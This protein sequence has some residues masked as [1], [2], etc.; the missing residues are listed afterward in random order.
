MPRLYQDCVYS[1]E[2]KKSKFITY[3]HRTDNEEDAKAFLMM[4]K[5]K[6]W[7]ATHHCTALIIGTT[8]RSNDDGEPAQTAGHPMLAVLQHEQMDHILAVV[9]RYFGGTKLGT[10]GLVRA[11]SSGV[12]NALKEAI[13]CKVQKVNEYE[14]CYPYDQT[15]KIESFLRR[16]HL[17]AGEQ[18]YGEQVTLHFFS[19]NDETEALSAATNGRIVPK[20]LRTIEKEIPIERK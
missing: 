5:K 19:P 18:E 17:E 16:R 1:A 11:Y 20:K 13:L 4:I 2:I 6:H 7:D 8:V 9:V 3:L 14:I 12:Q 10:G 15:G